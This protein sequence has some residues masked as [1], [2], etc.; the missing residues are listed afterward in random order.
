MLHNFKRLRRRIA[1][2]PLT[3][4]AIVMVSC[5]LVISWLVY[6]TESIHPNAN[7]HS[8]GDAV[9]W[10][11]VTFLTVG[12]GDRYPVTPEGRVLAGLLML[13]GVAAIGILTARISSYFLEQVLNRERSKINVDKLHQHFVVC[14]VKEDMERLLEHILEFNPD[15]KVSQLVIIGNFSPAFVEGLKAHRTLHEIQIVIGDYSQEVFLRRTVP[16]RARKILLLADRA[17]MPGGQIPSVKETDARTLMTAMLLSHI[18]RGVPVSAEV[19]DPSM[20]PYMRIAQVSEVIHSREY[21]RLLLANASG[22]TGLSNVIFD[23]LNPL[24]PTILNTLAIPHDLVGQPYAQVKQHLEKQH[25]GMM[26][27]GILENTGN[28]HVVKERALR[29][30]Q[31]TSDMNHLVQNLKAV[32]EMR[33]NSPVLNPAPDY[34]VP[35]GASAVVIETRTGTEKVRDRG[36]DEHV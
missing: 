19:L 13:C 25:A 10:G 14:G 5:W 22:G 2:E 16:E 30:A 36:A 1:D 17:Q 12:Y 27:I 4:A 18:A 15:L 35:A 3:K 7:I 6:R 20:D 26:I 33:F 24:T 23:L 11:I 8:Y 31:K 9:W 34:K 28:S 21:N 29:Q 32:K